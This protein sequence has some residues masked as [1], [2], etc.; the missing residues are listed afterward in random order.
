M[1][2]H[3]DF[4]LKATQKTPEISC[5]I[6]LGKIT[7]KGICT[8]E[9]V[10]DFFQPLKNWI[11]D[12]G[13]SAADKLEIS[14]FLDYFNTSTSRILLNLFRSALNLDEKGKQVNIYWNYENDDD[15]MKEAGEDYQSILGDLI[16]LIPISAN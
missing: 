16:H 9:D 15:D 11:D 8:P 12:F 5:D 7:I 13:D 4:N 14:V 3:S 1:L 6:N 10:I 2:E